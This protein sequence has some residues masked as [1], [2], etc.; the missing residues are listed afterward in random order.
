MKK[1][2]TNIK[3]SKTFKP[4]LGTALKYTITF[5]NAFYNPHSGHLATTTGTLPGGILSSTG[6]T[7]TGNVNGTHY[8]EDDGAG[9]VNA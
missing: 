3:I 5:S 8:L 9:L 7:E 2:K 1:W 4:T 6:F